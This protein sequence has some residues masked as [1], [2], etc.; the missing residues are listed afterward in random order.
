VVNEIEQNPTGT[1]DGYEWIELFDPTTNS[2][3]I[4]NWTLSTTAGVTVTLTISSGTIIQ[5]SGYYVVAYSSQWLDNEGESVILRDTGGNE[6]DRTPSLSDTYNDGRSWQRY[7]NGQDT[8]SETDWKFLLST[9]ED[10]NGEEPTPSTTPTPSPSLSPSP[11]TSQS[12]TATATITPIS[13]VTPT[14]SPRESL[15]FSPAEST[16]TPLPS[17]SPSESPE[18]PEISPLFLFIFLAVVTSV[19]VLYKKKSMR[20]ISTKSAF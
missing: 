18:I 3:N 13:T 2:V 5:A 16:A 19:F 8:D 12:P 15:T 6:V 20:V 9:K 1:D 14:P 4:S 17:I 10:S 7:P 11:S